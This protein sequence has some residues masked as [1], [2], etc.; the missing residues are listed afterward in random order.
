MESVRAL[1]GARGPEAGDPIY[2]FLRTSGWVLITFG[3]FMFVINAALLYF[4]G[5]EVVSGGRSPEHDVSVRS[6]AQVLRHLDARWQVWPVF[7]ARDIPPRGIEQFDQQTL[8]R[9]RRVVRPTRCNGSVDAI[10]TTANLHESLVRD[11][12]EG[13]RLAIRGGPPGAGDLHRNGSDVSFSA[14]IPANR[15]G[16]AAQFVASRIRASPRQTAPSGQWRPA[17]LIFRGTHRLMTR[18]ALHFN[19]RRRRSP[20]RAPS[21]HPLLRDM[22]RSRTAPVP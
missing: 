4:V 20:T 1:A 21:C 3:L 16:D 8:V 22:L 6:G 19:R 18:R 7:L 5:W 10:K 12:R 15:I 13:H 11:F 17:G 9:F 14:A 2:V